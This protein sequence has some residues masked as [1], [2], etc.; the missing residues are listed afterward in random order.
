MTLLAIKDLVVRFRTHEGT[1]HAVN[2]VSFQ[3]D[4]GETLGLVG[5]SGCGKTVTSLALVGLLPH[6]AGRVEGGQVLFADRDITRLTEP[7]MRQI[8]GRDIAFIFQ[9][10]MT[11]LNPVLTI[12]EQVVEAIRAHRILT[13]ADARRRAVEILGE[14]GIPSPESQLVNYPYQLSGGMRQR[15]MIAMALC[16]QP[17][18]LIADE[19]TT[20]LDVTVQAQVLDL[21]RRLVRQTSAAMILITHDLGVVAG[22][23]QRVHV[24]YAGFVVEEATTLELFGNP[25]HPYTVGLLHSI[26]DSSASEHRKLVPIE[27]APPSQ[28]AEPS[29]CPFAPRCAWRLPVCFEVN[30][31]L[32][33][34]GPAGPIVVTGPNA[35]H[36]I[37]CHNPPTAKEAQVGVPASRLDPGPDA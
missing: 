28:R 5:E 25:T 19:P 27:G 36:R 24:M 29:G 31:S 1:V 12:E 8:R 22:M 21:I 20:A 17:R 18:L 34:L 16:L 6:P 3:V 35:T 33:P 14:V 11:C 15:V 2:G 9:D 32:R 7:E 13:R 37:A 30:P 4:E 10:P 23:T 26:P